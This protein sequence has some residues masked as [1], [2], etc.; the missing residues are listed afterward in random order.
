MSHAF[1]DTV[2]VSNYATPLPPPLPTSTHPPAPSATFAAS[3]SSIT[4]AA[5]GATAADM[6]SSTARTYHVTG[7]RSSRNAPEHKRAGQTFSGGAILSTDA[8][9]VKLRHHQQVFIHAP[10]HHRQQR[11]ARFEPELQ[12]E[13]VPR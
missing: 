5:R 9:S 7:P 6:A 13:L 12:G 2:P 1:N 4:A 8:A 10:V 3:R 11:D